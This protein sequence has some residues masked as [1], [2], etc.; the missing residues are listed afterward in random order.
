MTSEFVAKITSLHSNSSIFH[1]N[2]TL[3][4]YIPP[5]PLST[6]ILFVIFL[7]FLLNLEESTY[8]LKDQC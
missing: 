7:T 8:N 5:S 4:F 3:M 2:S 1:W 6:M